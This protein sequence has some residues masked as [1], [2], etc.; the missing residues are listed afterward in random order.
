MTIQ[1]AVLLASTG[2]PASEAAIYT[3][4]ANGISVIKRAVFTNIDTVT[5]TLTVYR[6]ANGGSAGT[7]NT[8]ISAYRISP[9]QAYVSPELGN[10]V[11]N[12][13][14]SIHAFADSANKVNATMS[15]FTA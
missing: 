12:A 6:V 7:S 2:L 3:V 9:G 14:D 13:G 4:P 15:G 8:L 5:R 11:L 10:M 1:P